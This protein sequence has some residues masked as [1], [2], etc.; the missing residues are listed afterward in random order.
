MPIERIDPS[1]IMGLSGTDLV[2][3]IESDFKIR[4]GLCPNG[5]GLMKSSADGCQECPVCHFWT[6]K[7]AE[8]DAQ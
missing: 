4:S 7:A 8:L 3:Y 2:A 6:N 1:R 5:H